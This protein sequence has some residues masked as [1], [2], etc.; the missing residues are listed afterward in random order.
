MNRNLRDGEGG[1]PFHRIFFAVLFALIVYGL[2][3]AAVVALYARAAAKEFTRQ[4]EA[5]ATPQRQPDDAQPH[6]AV[7]P[8][9]PSLPGP[10]QA[11]RD[12]KPQAC[13]GGFIAHRLESGW[14]QGNDRCVAWGD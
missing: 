8:H 5:M 12:G 1:T 14:D 7:R 11:K 13:I 6:R 3:Q 2:L 10:V 4:V 9:L